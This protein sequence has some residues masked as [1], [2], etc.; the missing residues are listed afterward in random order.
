[1]SCSARCLNF[2][3]RWQ[4]SSPRLEYPSWEQ[5]T[6]HRVSRWGSITPALYRTKN[7]W[8]GFV[9]PYNQLT[10]KNRA[11]P[12]AH[13]VE[14]H[15]LADDGRGDLAFSSCWSS[16]AGSARSDQPQHHVAVAQKQHRVPALNPRRYSHDPHSALGL[17]EKHVS[18]G[19]GVF[20][21][22]FW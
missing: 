9:S 3:C 2:G 13:A 21:S 22:L 4:A 18:S 17:V 14:Q 8:T 7:D 11:V 1:M 5:C 20:L 12:A 19:V 16:G 10:N 6:D 15:R